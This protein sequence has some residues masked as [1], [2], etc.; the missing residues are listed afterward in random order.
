MPG[1]ARQRARQH[2]LDRR[3]F[4]V[5]GVAHDP[6]RAGLLVALELVLDRGDRAEPLH[7]GHPVPA[8]HDQPHREAVLRKERRAVHLV[9][10]QD[11][12]AER[13]GDAEAARV[14]VL[15]AALDRRGRGR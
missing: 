3:A 14:V 10:E 11:V 9:R 6:V 13:L 7:V 4:F 8:G 2:P 1:G 12:V 15:A 5:V